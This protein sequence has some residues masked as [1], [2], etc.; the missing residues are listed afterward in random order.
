MLMDIVAEWSLWG[1]P[2]PSSIPRSPYELTNSLPTDLVT[3]LQGVRRCGKS[4]FMYQM[5]EHYGLDHSKCF[6]I[7]F[8]DPRL[9]SSLN[10]ENF[11]K[12]SRILCFWPLFSSDFKAAKQVKKLHQNDT[13]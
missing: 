6:F 10:T 5:I 4:T 3:A 8:E 1:K 13:F 7:N 2:V 9:S 11:F 12:S